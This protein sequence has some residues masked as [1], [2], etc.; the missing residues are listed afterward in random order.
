MIH[1]LIMGPQT[2][3]NPFIHWRRLAV[4]DK[5][6]AGL[7]AKPE[8]VPLA[9]ISGKHIARAIDFPPRSSGRKQKG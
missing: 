5:I 2:V 8:S 6:F 1:V 7:A 4:F 9:L 3:Y